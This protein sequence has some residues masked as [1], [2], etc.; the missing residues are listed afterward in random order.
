MILISIAIFLLFFIFSIYP[1]GKLILEKIEVKLPFWEEVLVG[2]NIGIVFFT[3]IVF[4]LWRLNLYFLTYFFI[5][6]PILYI[7]FRILK[8]KQKFWQITYK[9]RQIDLLLIFILF[10]STFIPSL[11]VIK[12]GD[13]IEGGLRMIGAN[14]HDVLSYLAL[15]NNLQ[16]SIPP[17]NPTFAGEQIQNYHYLTY[18]F[19]S[20]VQYITKIPTLDLYFKIIMP[21]LAFLL[22]AT[23]FVFMKDLTGIK[24]I[25]YLA[26]MFSC[27]SSNLYYLSVNFYPIVNISPSI[28]WIDEYTTRMVNPQLILSY[29]LMLTILYLFLKTKNYRNLKFICVVSILIGSLMLFKAFAGVLIF[30]ALGIAALFYAINKKYDYLIIILFSGIITLGLFLIS[31][32]QLNSALFLSPLWF[33]KNMFESPDHLNFSQWELRRQT[34]LQDG[35]FPR[36]I[37][38]Y[39]QGLLIFL[40]GNLG[41]RFLGI[42]QILQKIDKKDIVILLLL[43]V[44]LGLILPQ[45]FLVKGTVWNSIQFSYY[46]VFILGVLTPYIL[47]NLFAKNKLLFLL[48]FS[49]SWIS[50]LPGVYHSTNNYFLSVKDS[51]IIPASFYQAALALKDEEDGIVLI[52]PIFF[53]NTFIPAISSKNAYFAD[54]MWLSVQTTPFAG[55]KQQTEEF[56]KGNYLDPMN[57]LKENNIKYIVTDSSKVDNFKNLN[58]DKVYQ[59]EQI[60]VFK[61]ND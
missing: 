24:K 40:F 9:F 35:N 22:S 42:F 37:Q 25:G 14:G 55:R 6:F 39:A 29:I 36:I 30:T 52:H 34:Y 17:Q 58:L 16:K 1:L 20:G 56:F 50:L 11:L 28:L 5:F 32:A 49:I 54:E 18:V 38:M 13:V 41:L 19:F 48:I 7:I 8:S 10:I 4:V 47:Y 27:L 23:V 44:V 57:F 46:S 51:N 15:I 61:V 2:I 43:I 21:T 53:N 3:L 31:N 12:S 60:N 33:V 26:V 59:S 45:L